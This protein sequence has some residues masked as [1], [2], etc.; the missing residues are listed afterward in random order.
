M[1]CTTFAS[2]WELD[3]VQLSGIGGQWL[4]DLPLTSEVV[5]IPEPGAFLTVLAGIGLLTLRLRRL[6]KMKIELKACN[7]AASS[8]FNSE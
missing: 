6:S 7:V 1:A 3:G 5:P 2:A 8:R 4:I